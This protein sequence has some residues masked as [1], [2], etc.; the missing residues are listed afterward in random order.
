MSGKRKKRS[1]IGVT[2]SRGGGR[3]MWWFY[4]LALRLYGAVPVRL[5]AP[6]DP[7]ELAGF[8]GFI[9]GGGDDISPDLYRGDTLIDARLD[10]ERDAMELAVLDHATPRDIP[11]L[12]VC[13]GAQMINVHKGGNLHQ[14]VREVYADLPP[15]W[16]PLPRKTVTFEEPSRLGQ[17]HACDCVRVNSLHNQAIDTTGKNIRIVGRDEFGIPQAFEDTSARFLM[18]V[19]W[20]PEFLLYRPAHRR[21][22]RAFLAAVRDPGCFPGT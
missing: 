22:F 2:T 18:G 13:R 3:Y 9:I 8:D 11:V 17:I 14:N 15:M 12:G 4:W 19:Q 21:L 6:L 10:P 1:R 20:H 7:S 16:T 5:L